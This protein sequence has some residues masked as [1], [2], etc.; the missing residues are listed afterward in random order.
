MFLYSTNLYKGISVKHFQIQLF[1]FRGCP[2]SAID[3]QERITIGYSSRI[4]SSVTNQGPISATVIP[5]IADIAY[6][7]EVPFGKIY[8]LFPATIAKVVAPA[9]SVIGF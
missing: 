8:R 2:C 5:D 7:A 4:C 3:K 1:R 6:V 9:V